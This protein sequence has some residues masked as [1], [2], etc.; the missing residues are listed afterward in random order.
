[1]QH[2]R[3]PQ[4]QEGRDPGREFPGG[5]GCEECGDSDDR[6]EIL[7]ALFPSIHLA[8][9]ILL[10]EKPRR[11][12]VW[13]TRGSLWLLKGLSWGGPF[14]S[15]CDHCL[16]SDGTIPVPSPPCM[17]SAFVFTFLRWPRPPSQG[18]FLFFWVFYPVCHD[19]SF[20]GWPEPSSASFLEMR[21]Q[22]TFLRALTCPEEDSPCSA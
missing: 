20:S 5:P 12:W 4:G 7:G 18:Q 8:A 16:W 6:L 14:L 15:L 17:L 3:A 19:I 2:S 22:V 1:M 9:Q 10:L 11:T 21:W 13:P